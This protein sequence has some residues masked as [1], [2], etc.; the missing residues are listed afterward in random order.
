MS[1]ILFAWELGDNWGHLS[2][3]LPVARRLIAAGQRVL[4]AVNNTKIAL[5]ILGPHDI[6]FVQA[7]RP[8]SVARI[9]Q[10]LANH[11][12]MLIVQGYDAESDSLSGLVS[13]WRGL[14]DLFNPDVVVID[15]APTAVL[16]AR[17]CSIPTVLTGSGFELPPRLSPLPAFRPWEKLPS[18]RL[19]LTE[20]L[21]LENI[22][23]VMT[24]YGTKPLSQF[25]DLFNGEPKILTTFSELDHYGARNNQIYAGPVYELP[26]AHLTSWPIDSGRA[27][28]F[29]YLRS[30]ITQV[31]SLLLAL[32]ESN[33]DVICAFPGAS[34]ALI[35]RY[36]TKHLQ[37]FS[38]AVSLDNILPHT[39]IFIGYGSG[40][41]A[42]SL[43]AGIPLL[44]TP[45]MIEQFLGAFRVEALGAGLIAKDNYTKEAYANGIRTLLTEARF[46]EAARGFA[47][48]YHGF[49]SGQAADFIADTVLGVLQQ[50][51][52]TANFVC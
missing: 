7:P 24:R 5:D 49:D 22:N 50:P 14:F 8:R 21:A 15:Y 27:R 9:T 33:A 38:S 34:T 11:A 44:L 26:K 29:A 23:R 40:A 45:F 16:A 25:A 20:E 37:I 52:A 48:K 2:R 19:L 17:T 4:F 39:D 1:N 42:A 47:E 30:G 51:P 3:D 10:P 32:A 18:Q 31:E 43:L 13:G 6:P 41:I 46:R 35:Q 12:E 28:I 36:Q